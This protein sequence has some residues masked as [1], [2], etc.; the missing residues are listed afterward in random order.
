MHVFQ[1]RPVSPA[2]FGVS[3][4]GHIEPDYQ[5]RRS[6][7]VTFCRE[8]PTFPL[9]SPTGLPRHPHCHADQHQRHLAQRATIPG[10]LGPGSVAFADP[11]I[12]LVVGGFG[13]AAPAS[14]GSSIRLQIEM[15][16]FTPPNYFRSAPDRRCGRPGRRWIPASVRSTSRRSAWLRHAEATVLSTP[17]QAIRNPGRIALMSLKA[18]WP[19]ASS[20]A[21]RSISAIGARHC[22][23]PQVA[24]AC[25]VISRR[26]A[27]APL[28]MT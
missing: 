15:A 2:P 8:N 22:A 18:P 26:S 20:S 6:T 11:A 21:A 1:R 7:F 5:A 23:S 28:L 9:Q 27:A 19:L 24:T 10:R 16:D 12:V 13:A 4:T 25:R 17:G 3:V 14:N